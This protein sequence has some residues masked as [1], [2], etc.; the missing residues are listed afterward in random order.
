MLAIGIELLRGVYVATAY[1]DRARVEWPPHPARLFSA[2]VATWAEDEAA[3]ERAALEWLERQPAPEL[4]ASPT[5]TT[6][7]RSAATVFVPVNDASFV[8]PADPATLAPAARA[9][10]LAV[11][12]KLAGN[13]LDQAERFATDHRLRQPRT[14]PTVTPEW[15][16][17]AFVWRD[18]DPSPELRAALDQL[19]RRLVRLGHSSSMVAGSLLAPEALEDLAMRAARFTPDDD[20]ALSL[21]WI[22]AGQLDALVREHAHHQEVEPRV[23]PAL[24]VRYREG[25]AAADE[26]VAT[27]VFD[28]QLVVLARTGG[29][30]LPITS[31]AGVARQLRRAL[32]ADHPDGVDEAL[33]GHTPD[34]EASERPHLAIVPLPFVMGPHPD[35]SILGVALVLPRELGAEARRAIMRA[36]GELERKGV[37]EGDDDVWTVQLALG[38]AGTLELRRDAWGQERRATLLP[39]TWTRPARHWATATPIALDRNPGDLHHADPA[40]R[41]QAFREATATIAEGLTRIGAPRPIEVDVLRSTVLPGTA[42]PNAYPRYPIHTG[43]PQRVLVHARVTFAAPVRGPVLVGAGRYHGLGLLLPIDPVEAP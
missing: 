43:R 28:D 34:G 23:L 33:S 26:P 25:D 32:M 18:A 15:P 7:G 6:R 31:V 1:N 42:K 11:P 10:L 39:Q 41:A 36:I 24:F 21:R 29:P 20:G 17:F 16:R 19:V 14:F 30:R 40:K 12:A 5:A 8:A 4:L 35:G 27:T 9:K 3:A 2:L 38:D 13:D 37:R 22:R